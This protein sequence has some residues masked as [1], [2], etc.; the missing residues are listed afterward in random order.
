MATGVLTRRA[1]RDD[2]QQCVER[3]SAQ[4]ADCILFAGD[5]C[6]ENTGG[7]IYGRAHDAD[8]ENGT[9]MACCQR[10]EALLSFGGKDEHR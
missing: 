1:A 3:F 9:P 2:T 10:V 4:A 5:L 6:V 8:T 7:C